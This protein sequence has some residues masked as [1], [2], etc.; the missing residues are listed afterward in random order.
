MKIDVKRFAQTLKREEGMVRH[1]Y[2]DTE[3]FLTIGYGRCVDKR[4]GGG[5]T[6]DEAEYLLSN[7][8][9][10]VLTKLSIALPWVAQLDG[11]R[12]AALALMAFQLGIQGLMGFTQ[13]LAAVRDGRYDHAEVLMLDSKWAKQTPARAKRVA[14]QMATGEWQ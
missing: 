11:V 7:D 5:L 4:K 2:P 13:T 8:V 9:E 3:G 14:R 10:D 1:A 6:D 12:Q